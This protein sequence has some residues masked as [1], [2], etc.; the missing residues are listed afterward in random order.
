MIAEIFEP[1]PLGESHWSVRRLADE[2]GLSRSTVHR[3]RRERDLEPHQSHKF[4]YSNGPEFEATTDH[5]GRATA[6]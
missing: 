3:I 4:K 5:H 6:S 1:T 2:L